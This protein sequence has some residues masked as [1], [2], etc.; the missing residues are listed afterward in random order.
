[1]Q[2]ET[3]TLVLMLLTATVIGLCFRLYGIMEQ[4]PLSDEAMTVYTA[5]NYVERG[6]FRP[7]MPQHP[8]LRDVL[9]HGSTGVLGTGVLGVRGFSLLFGTLS[10]PLLGLLLYRLSGRRTASI[11][12]AVF[13]AVDPVHIMFSRQSIQEVHTAFF[14]LLGCTAALGGWGRA[15][16]PAFWVTLPLSGIFFGLGLAS[17]AHAVIPMAVCGVLLAGQAA[18]RRDASLGVLAA[19]SFTV[20]PL[21]VYLATYIPWFSRGYTIPDWIFMQKA[22]A[23][24]VVTDLGHDVQSVLDARAWLWFIKPFMGWGNFTYHLGKPYVSIAM[25]NP[26]L[27]L[28][29]LPSSLY[30][31]IR[32]SVPGRTTWLLQ[33]LFWSSYLPLVLAQR[34]ITIFS[35]I[36]VIPFAY[37]LV[38]LAWDAWSEGGSRKLLYG[39]VTAAC[40]ATMALFPLS[41]GKA[42]EY[43]YPDAFVERFNPHQQERK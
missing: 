36:A 30:L 41:M 29:V 7:T 20:L 2:N 1:M 26:V 18:R 24:A 25:A 19:L 6:Q 40:I 37:C 5:E 35:S 8:R 17:K 27:W 34:P 42:T 4:P 39:Y 13:L 14:F 9:I 22:L 10:I 15:G 43:N 38:G 33:A 11:L 16:K 3:K 28:M 23:Y 32:P 21:A 31:L 12:A